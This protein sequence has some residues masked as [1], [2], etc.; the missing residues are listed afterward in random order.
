MGIMKEMK[1]LVYLAC[2]SSFMALGQQHPDR[3]IFDAKEMATRTVNDLSK[4][5]NI[6][7]AILDSLKNVFINFYNEMDKDRKSNNHPDMDRMRKIEGNRDLKVKALL[8]EEQFK[9]YT[10]FMEN[11]RE[12]RK[13]PPPRGE[14]MMEPQKR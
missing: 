12:K 10:K 8:S 7:P 9:A 4:E 6:T 14:G 11:E 13:G 2:L 1:F 3:P 5:L